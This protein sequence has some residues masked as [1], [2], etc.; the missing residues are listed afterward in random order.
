MLKVAAELN[1]KTHD[2]TV[3]QGPLPKDVL[4]PQDIADSILCVLGA[5]YVRV[6]K[7]NIMYGVK[8]TCA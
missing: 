2:P 5:P 4:D 3:L 1:G 6:I 7:I 8:G